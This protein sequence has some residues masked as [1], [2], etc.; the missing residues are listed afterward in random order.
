MGHVTINKG[1]AVDK[2]A[3]GKRARARARARERE[4]EREREIE[5]GRKR[6]RERERDLRVD[7]NQNVF[8]IFLLGTLA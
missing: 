4:R 7:P 6:K 8:G 5:R 3:E 1:A 2:T